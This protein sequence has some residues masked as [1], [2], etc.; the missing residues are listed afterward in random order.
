MAY[1]GGIFFANRGVGVVRIISE[2]KTQPLGT[3]L[4]QT[5]FFPFAELFSVIIAGNF[6]A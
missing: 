6:T 5:P 4:L 1:F 2:K 3:K